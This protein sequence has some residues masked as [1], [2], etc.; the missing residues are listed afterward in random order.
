MIAPLGLEEGGLDGVVVCGG[1][2][3]WVC[4]V[5]VFFPLSPL[6]DDVGVWMG[7]EG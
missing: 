1:V 5:C 2:A 6:M 3:W 7:V 4:L